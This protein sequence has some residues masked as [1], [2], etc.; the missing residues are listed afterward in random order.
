MAKLRTITVGELMQQL[1]DYDPSQPVIFAADYGDRSHTEQALPI[2]GRL[3]EV[4]VRESGYSDS[5]FAIN[6]DDYDADE[7]Y[8]PFVVIR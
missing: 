1:T 3:E 5:G 4:T 2:K 8:E 7:D 6:D